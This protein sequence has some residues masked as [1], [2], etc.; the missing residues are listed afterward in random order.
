MKVI[1]GLFV[2]LGGI[3]AA[4]YYSGAFSMDV[5][6]EVQ[7]FKDGVKP[8][9]SWEAVMEVKAAKKVEYWMDLDWR[10]PIDLD[11]DQH[12]ARLAGPNATAF[13]FP[14]VFSADDQYYV[15]FNET[16][17]VLAVT[18]KRTLKDLPGATGY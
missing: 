1:L 14:Y 11:V 9:M 10:L 5:E 18:P 13:R 16:G 7:A 15:E 12:K 8:G 2:V 4:V 3:G 17:T 6:G